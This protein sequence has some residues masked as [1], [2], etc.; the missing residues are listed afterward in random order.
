M[1]SSQRPP[2]GIV[3][4]VEGLKKLAKERLLKVANEGTSRGARLS[5]M[6]QTQQFLNQ[7]RAVQTSSANSDL[8]YPSQSHTAPGMDTTRAVFWF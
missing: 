7:V 2:L 6:D 5:T 8:S 4:T 1:Y 3:G